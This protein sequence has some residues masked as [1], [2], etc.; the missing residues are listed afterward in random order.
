MLEKP[1]KNKSTRQVKIIF[2]RKWKNFAKGQSRKRKELEREKLEAARA[3]LI[4]VQAFMS[5]IQRD[6]EHDISIVG[7]YYRSKFINAVR[8][9]MTMAR[10]VW[11]YLIDSN[12]CKLLF[13]NIQSHQR[14]WKT[15]ENFPL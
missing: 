12:N 9:V 15:K 11:S 3:K 10:Y 7:A 8:M 5:T 13:K 14:L 6:L 4:T 1:T 2:F